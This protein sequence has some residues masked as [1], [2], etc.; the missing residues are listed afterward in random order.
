MRRRYA[1]WLSTR[2]GPW[3]KGKR[4]AA[5]PAEHVGGALALGGDRINLARRKETGPAKR[6]TLWE[7]A[8]S[9]CGERVRYCGCCYVAGAVMTGAPAGATAE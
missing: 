9:A 3:S 1:V 6:P 2:A 4:R 8:K 5:Y 7:R